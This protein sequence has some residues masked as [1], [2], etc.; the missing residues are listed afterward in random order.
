V[1]DVETILRSWPGWDAAV[2]ALTQHAERHG[3]RARAASEELRSRY[4]DVPAAM[5]IDAVASRQRKYQSTVQPF[6]QRYLDQHP[7]LTLRDLSLT[8]AQGTALSRRGEPQTVQDTALGLLRFA[9]EH[10]LSETEAVRAWGE[11]TNGLTHAH[12]LDPYVGSVRGIGV[13]LFAYLRMLAGADG[14]KPD[15]RVRN[16]F[17]RL[18][19]P[20]LYSDVA[21]LHLAAVTAP[22]ADLTLCELDQLLWLSDSL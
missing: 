2:R 11:A 19:F 21:L 18:G 10:T 16:G 22:L 9:D 1:G 8:G 4:R 7:S 20:V 6:V 12:R 15:V 3:S 17:A 5:V 14:L 13:A